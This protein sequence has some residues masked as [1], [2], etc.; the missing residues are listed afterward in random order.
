MAR[1]KAIQVKI[2]TA[3]VIKALETRLAKL[4]ADYEK[5]DENANKYQKKKEAWLR[6]FD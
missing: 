1:G 2:P 5:Q 6:E 4:K 3:K